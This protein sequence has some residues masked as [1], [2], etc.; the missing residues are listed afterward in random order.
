MHRGKL[1]SGRGRPRS[2]GGPL[3][4]H[5][6]ILNPKAGGGEF[7]SDVPKPYQAYLIV[8][9]NR[10]P[11]SIFLLLCIL[12]VST[13]ATLPRVW[14]LRLLHCAI[15]SQDSRG[16]HVGLQGK[17]N[18]AIP[19][20]APGIENVYQ[21]WCTQAC[22][23]IQQYLIEGIR[24]ALAGTQVQSLIMCVAMCHIMCAM[25]HNS[26]WRNNLSINAHDHRDPV[27]QI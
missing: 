17:V 1:Q 24:L 16:R 9:K 22:A 14:W 20:L 11:L 26:S 19:R 6:Q 25:A 21:R 8:N 5:S 27:K 23:D 3:R 12:G 18:R 13:R 10:H 2:G 15:L 7:Q 4:N